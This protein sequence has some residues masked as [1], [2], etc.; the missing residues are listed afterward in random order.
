MVSDRR[1]RRRRRA[2]QGCELARSHASSIVTTA[3]LIN[4]AAGPQGA[5]SGGVP[6]RCAPAAAA[7][8]RTHA[9]RRAPWRRPRG[10]RRCAACERPASRWEG[11]ARAR[12]GARAGGPRGRLREIGAGAQRRP[13]RRA[14]RCRCGTGWVGA[15]AEAARRKENG[16]RTGK[17]C[18]NAARR[19]AWRPAQLPSCGGGPRRSVGELA[20][21]RRRC[22]KRILPASARG[23]GR[24]AVRPRGANARARRAVHKT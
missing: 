7:W 5:A 11:R 12:S 15:R 2:R 4:R 1:R 14:T 6:C 17:A 9:V 22:M 16:V 18:A 23:L 13:R 19:A 3:E 24:S 8:R 21:S 20:M 10:A